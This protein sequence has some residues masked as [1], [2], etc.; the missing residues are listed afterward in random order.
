MRA[1]DRPRVRVTRHSAARPRKCFHQKDSVT[2][3]FHPEWVGLR[4][5]TYMLLDV[6][7]SSF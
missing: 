1:V 4:E 5:I 2:K 7:D 3:V 6:I